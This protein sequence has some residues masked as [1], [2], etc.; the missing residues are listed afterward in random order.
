[1]GEILFLIF[2]A[3]VA[4]IIPIMCR[5]LL[6]FLQVLVGLAYLI[7]MVF[8]KGDFDLTGWTGLLF[9]L[10]VLGS[11]CALSLRNREYARD[12]KQSHEMEYHQKQG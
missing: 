10:W 11:L 6:E 12:A 2:A 4:F 7:Y 1:M 3:V 9:V 5:V 8:I